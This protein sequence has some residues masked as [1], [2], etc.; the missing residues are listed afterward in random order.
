MAARALRERRIQV[1]QEMAVS[2][3]DNVKP[4]EFGYPALTR[5]HI[6]RERIGHIICEI[7]LRRSH[8]SG[9]REAEIA[10]DPELVVP[11]STGRA[12][13]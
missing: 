6:L 4:S 1:A 7:F 5:V 10:I 11:D 3:F 2:G 9:A 12:R 8:P 13:Q